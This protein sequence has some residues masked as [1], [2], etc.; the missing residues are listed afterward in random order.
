MVGKLDKEIIE[1]FIEFQEKTGRHSELY[2]EDV[3]FENIALSNEEYFTFIKGKNKYIQRYIKVNKGDYPI[4]GSSLKNSCISAYIKP[5]DISDIVNQKSVTFNK[6]NAKGSVPFFRDYPYLMDRHHISIIPNA[7]LVDAK[8]LQK[9]LIRFFEQSKFG[10]GDNVADVSAVQKHFVPI[11]KDLNKFY[12]SFQIQEAI[13]EFLEFWKDGYTDVIRDKVSKKKPIYE[14]IRRIVVQNTFKYDKFLVEKFNKFSIDKGYNLKLEN[15]IFKE[16]DFFS[17]KQQDLFLPKKLEKNQ[18][19]ILKNST[20]DGIP[21]YTGGKKRLCYVDKNK[22]LDK[23]FIPQKNNP[24]I[25]FANNG[26]GSAGRNFFVHYKPYF[27]N[28]E[29]TIVSFKNDNDYYSLYIYHFIKDM[30]DKYNM[31]RDNRPTP[32]DLPRFGIRVKK[33][34]AIGNYSSKEIQKILAEF[35]KMI[36]EQIDEKLT[37]YQSMLELTDIIDRAFLYRTFSKMDWSKE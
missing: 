32:K 5:I 29:R 8:Y 31:N 36:I 16:N 37:I 15:I 1:K 20:K 23:I 27:V 14:S 3:E 28:Q 21:V 19:L 26:D 12:S 7:D 9:S 33:P 17:N 24:D 34:L 18:E 2:I 25:S 6:D 4:L 30:R 11:P 22:Y 35:W 10:W 13:V